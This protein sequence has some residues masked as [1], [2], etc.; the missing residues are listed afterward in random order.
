MSEFDIE[1]L[2]QKLSE[3]PQSPLFARLA[4][5]FLQKEQYSEALKLCEEGIQQF[6]K[7]Y[8]GYLVLGKVCLALKEYSTARDAFEHALD[9]SPFNEL[10]AKLLAAVPAQPDESVRTS[11]ETYFEPQT[12]AAESQ[13]TTQLNSNERQFEPQIPAQSVEEQI[14]QQFAQQSAQQ[15]IHEKAPAVEEMEFNY[16]IPEP[17]TAQPTAAQEIIEDQNPEPAPQPEMQR[18]QEN[19]E[20][21]SAVVTPKFPSFDE[22]YSQRSQNAQGGTVSTLD[23]YLG[24]NGSSAPA[25][26]QEEYPA[27][28]SQT[29]KEF[30]E[31][32]FEPQEPAQEPAVE[33]HQTP[34]PV[35]TSPEQ[36][37]LFAEMAAE[38]TVEEEKPITEPKT[39][40]DDIAE[41]LQKV[42][43]IVPQEMPPP[44]P[45]MEETQE[46]QAAE[47]E[48]V[49]PTLAE[50]YASQGEYGAAIQAYEILMFSHPGKTAEYQQRI[51]ELQKK[52]LEKEGL[53]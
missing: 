30:S 21:L 47:S 7:Y 2:S 49:T 17:P 19:L 46:D 1:F 39:T 5:L 15:F 53:L 23:E 26:E 27:A 12:P 4:D 48:M 10:T 45:A 44:P 33:Q 8:A 40:I 34:E 28:Q 32:S 18:E 24:G 38:K 36:S 43:R 3:N 13:N 31:P 6:P 42:E 29:V 9:L 20:A 41:K 37:Q 22:Y 50:I 52:Q 16:A 51:R 14:A 11:D 25:A 35:F